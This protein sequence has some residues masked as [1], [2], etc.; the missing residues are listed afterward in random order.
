M[1]SINCGEDE[2]RII[3]YYKWLSYKFNY[4]PK[5][6]CSSL[7]YNILHSLMCIGKW[8]N[9]LLALKVNKHYIQDDVYI[10]TSAKVYIY[11]ETDVIIKPVII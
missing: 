5:L 7:L 6:I 1:H 3:W 11:I 10:T 8:K 4:S 9:D 2:T